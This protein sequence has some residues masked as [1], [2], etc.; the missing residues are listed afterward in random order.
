MADRLTLQT[1]LENLLGSENVYFQPPT[2]IRMEYPAIRYVLSDINNDYAD[3]TVYNQNR[4]YDVTLI[5]YDPDS[6]FVNILNNIPYCKFSRFYAADGLN[7]WV[8]KLTY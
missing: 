6:E 7:H 3:D 2:N 4:G 1:F 5:D 8:F